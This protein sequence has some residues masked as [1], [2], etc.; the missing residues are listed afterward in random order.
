MKM[1]TTYN[2]MKWSS[3]THFEQGGHALCKAEMPDGIEIFLGDSSEVSCPFCQ[4]IADHVFLDEYY[5]N[6]REVG[7][8][9]TKE[10]S[11]KLYEAARRYQQRFNHAV[12]CGHRLLEAGS[13]NDS[14]EFLAFAAS[15]PAP[16]SNSYW[17]KW[18]VR[19][20]RNMQDKGVGTEQEE[21]ALRNIITT[22]ME[23]YHSLKGFAVINDLE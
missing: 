8:S 10:A 2:T 21:I 5:N 23:P 4:E 17:S 12:T 20:L 9:I 3:Y 13:G 16:R 19:V 18:A 11:K 7:Y 1:F 22:G 6:A 15:F 14:P